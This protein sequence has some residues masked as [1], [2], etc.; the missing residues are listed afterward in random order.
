MAAVLAAAICLPAAAAPTDAF[1]HTDEP[2]G[3]FSSGPAREMYAATRV[4]TAAGLGLEDSLEG[5][6]DICSGPDGTIY[7][8]CGDDSR[9]ILLNGDYTLR[10]ELVLTDE[11]G[12]VNFKGAKG[13]FVD[14]D[15]DIYIADSQNARVLVAGGDGRV[16]EVWEA[17]QSSLIPADFLYQ[18][19][20]ISVDG[21]GYTYILSLGCFYGALT[22]SPQGEFMGFYGANTV[23]ATALDTLSFLWDKLTKNDAKR[24]ASLKTMPY[25]FVDLALDAEGYMVTCTGRTE[26]AIE[27]GQ[28]RKVS[29]GGQDILYKRGADGTSVS[30][31]SVNF[32][33]S[34][35]PQRSGYQN[36]MSIAVDRDGFIFALDDTYGLI[37]VYDGECSLVNGFGGGVGAGDQLGTFHTPVSLA[38]HG[39]SLLV[40]DSY[41]CSVTVF[42]LTPYG[43]ALRQAHILYLQGDYEEAE[44]LWQEVLAGD[45]GCQAAYR[46]LA[47]ASYSRG[48]YS[49][50]LR[51][52]E[53]GLDYT[54]YDLAWQAT[55]ADWT[56]RHFFWIFPLG[57]LV[58]GG[59]IALLVLVRKRRLVLVPNPRLRTLLSVPFHP[60]RSFDELKYKKQ[61]SLLAGGVLAALLYLAFALKGT[62]SGFLFTD[63]AAKD[64]NVLYTLAQTVGLLLLWTLSN[65]L[66][67]S[68]FSGKGRLGEVFTATAYALLPLIAFT[69]LRVALSHVLPLSG[70]AFLDGLQTVVWIFTF[71]LLCVAMMTVHEYD[72]F[73]FLLT[74]IAVV[75]LMVMIVFVLFMFATLLRQVVDFVSGVYEEIVYR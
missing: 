1:T 16:R 68:L 8:L 54:V 63:T 55:L 69:F 18:P 47:M 21:D 27:A 31:S 17:P 41:T 62:A 39:T 11:W 3:S 2:G 10:Q 24:A 45:R 33:E 9:L 29:P 65:W 20:S 66:V 58:A 26:G 12:E 32:L 73:K 67:C 52:A 44:P 57:L 49:A 25:S 70:L 7:L 37:Y 74:G 19:V 71:F 4:I 43:E 23:K 53:A 42:T 30:S 60:F 72:F 6:T 5:L 13:I 61:G 59:A 38:V 46:G 50:A 35:V 15:G 34:E 51:Y 40:A 56:A 64:Y 28:I 14:A 36:L 48:D 75:F 22:Y